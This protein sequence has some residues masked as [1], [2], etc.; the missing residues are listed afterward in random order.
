MLAYLGVR[1]VRLL[2][3]NPE[4]AGGLSAL[5]VDVRQTVAMPVSVNPHNGALPRKPSAAE[6]AKSNSAPAQ[7][8]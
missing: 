8:G 6:P 2:T 5:G 1:S 7:K 4:K 3:N